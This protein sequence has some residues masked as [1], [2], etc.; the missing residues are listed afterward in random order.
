MED[1][2]TDKNT[3][4]QLPVIL[5]FFIKLFQIILYVPIQIIFIPFAIIGIIVAIYKEMGKSKKLVL[6]QVIIDG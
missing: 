3:K 4:K 2:M 5:R 1:L 6:S